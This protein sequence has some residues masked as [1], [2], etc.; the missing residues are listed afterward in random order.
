MNGKPYQ[1]EKY[2]R[3]VWISPLLE[4]LRHAECLCWNCTK[5]KPA[6]SNNC[7]IAQSLFDICVKHDVATPVTRCPEFEAKQR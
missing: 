7:P 3:V 5:L 4:E 2:G 6:Q 1:A